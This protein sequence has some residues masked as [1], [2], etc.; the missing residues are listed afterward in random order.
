MATFYYATTDFSIHALPTPVGIILVR[1]IVTVHLSVN[2]Y[3]RSPGEMRTI[4]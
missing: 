2:E 3:A 4:G 1:V